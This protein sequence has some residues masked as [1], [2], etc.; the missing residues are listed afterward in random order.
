VLPD[1]IFSYQKFP[2]TEYFERLWN[3]K[4]W[5]ISQLFGIYFA[6]NWQNVMATLYILF[7][8]GVIFSHFGLLYQGKSGNPDEWFTRG[9]MRETIFLAVLCAKEKAIF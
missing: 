9:W 7:S 5:Y 2:I 8:L 1:G 6:V 3:V 4:L